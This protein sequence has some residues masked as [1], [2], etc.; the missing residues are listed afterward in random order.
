MSWPNTF[1]RARYIPA[2]EYIQANRARVLLN[3]KMRSLFKK[4]DLYVVP[5]FWGDNLLRTN[6]T[7]HPCVVIPNGFDKS[8]LPSSISFIGDLYEEGNIISIAKEY[9]KKTNW[10]KKYPPNF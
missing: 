8:G 9:Q 1:R 6:L 4:I 2:V 10:H 3:D 5:S 7:G